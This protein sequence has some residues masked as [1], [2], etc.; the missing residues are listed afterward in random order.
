[1]FKAVLFDLDGTLIHSSWVWPKIAEIYLAQYGLQIPEN[2]D[3]LEGKSFTEIAQYFKTHFQIPQTIDEIK[4]T[5]N[6]MGEALYTTQMTLKDD[7]IVFLELL[8]KLGLKMGIATS[9]SIEMTE[10]AL[11]YLQVRKYFDVICTSCMVKIGKP[12]PAIYLE[13][14]HRLGVMPEECLVLE[15][16]PNGV[17]AAKVAGMTVWVIRDT[18]KEETVNILKTLAD[19][20]FEDYSAVKTAFEKLL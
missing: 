17:R 5:W 13:T 9:N 19:A 4:T 16:M 20:Y 1:M 18:T 14:A 6:E 7:V 3:G 15:D 11:T 2:L 12:H 8:S 10:K